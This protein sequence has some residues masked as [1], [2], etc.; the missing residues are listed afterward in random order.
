MLTWDLKITKSLF[1][2]HRADSKIEL[3]NCANNT[4][5]VLYKLKN[6]ILL[7]LRLSILIYYLN[8]A[9]NQKGDNKRGKRVQRGLYRTLEG[10][11]IN[12]DCN[13]AAK[14]DSFSRNLE[15]GG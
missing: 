7:K 1:R 4:G 12:A 6:H 14:C 8:Y 3:L 9:K 2:F 11:L 15:I 13:G 5:F 10:F